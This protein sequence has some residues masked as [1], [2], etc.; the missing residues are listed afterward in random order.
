MKRFLLLSAAI[1][2]CTAAC[3]QVEFHRS[4]DKARR[5]ADEKG[6]P[7]FVDLYADWCGPCRDMEATV[8]SRKEVGEF[9]SQHFVAL[10]ID[11]ESATGQALAAKY[12]IRSIPTFMVLD[13]Q[14]NLLG[15]TSGGRPARTFLRDM[16]TILDGIKE[17]R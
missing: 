8:F 13:T 2:L 15:I 7:V 6:L 9:M 16:Q 11:I 12:N 10:K 1:C 3:A 5:I 4:A 14:G 17:N